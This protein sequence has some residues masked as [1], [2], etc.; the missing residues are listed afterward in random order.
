M[1]EAN[2]HLDRG[3]IHSVYRFRISGQAERAA[4][5]GIGT[6]FRAS[7]N[8]DWNFVATSSVDDAPTILRAT[9]SAWAEDVNT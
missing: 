2:L 5:Q 1:V 4:S 9:G 7:C 6:V 3:S 8:V